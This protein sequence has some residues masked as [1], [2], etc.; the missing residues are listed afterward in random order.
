MSKRV[1][2]LALKISLSVVIALV[3]MFLV[4][5]AMAIVKLNNVKQEVL[6]KNHEINSVEEVN[7]LGQ[8]GEQHSGYVLE[9]KKDSSTLFRVW[10]NEEGEIKDEEIIS[11]N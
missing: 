9:V 8:W 6:E 7:S 3:V 10:A 2:N 1:T 11:S 4:I 5:K